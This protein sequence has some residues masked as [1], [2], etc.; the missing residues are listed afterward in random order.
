MITF[1][2]YSMCKYADFLE[3]LRKEAAEIPDEGLYGANPEDTPFMDSFLKES[4]RLNPLR[5]GNLPT[6]PF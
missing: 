3:P 1:M 6:S 4:A 2:L 5:I